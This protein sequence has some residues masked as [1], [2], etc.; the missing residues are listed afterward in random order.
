MRQALDGTYTYKA[1]MIE[2]L[3]ISE[4]F[5]KFVN[6][7]MIKEY[8]F[9]DVFFR[10]NNF[11]I[12]K[13]VRLFPEMKNKDLVRADSLTRM[14]HIWMSCRIGDV[15]ELIKRLNELKKKYKLYREVP[16][17]A[18]EQAEHLLCP[19]LDSRVNKEEITKLTPDLW[20]PV[21]D[22]LDTKDQLEL[23]KTCRSLYSDVRQRVIGK[24][25][26][27]HPHLE[28]ISPLRKTLWLALVPQVAFL[29]FSESRISSSRLSM[30]S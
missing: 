2:T 14:I 16:E 19:M 8:D 1:W 25:L 17:F 3:P 7:S 21:L 22:Y 13:N 20:F 24:V 11:F 6:Q 10:H 23:A 28:N 30:K 12:E 4:H 29:S 27:E 9:W 26:I 5:E 18:L 15:A